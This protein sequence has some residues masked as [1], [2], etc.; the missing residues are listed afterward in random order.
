MFERRLGLEM[1]EQ[2]K[3]IGGALIF[4]AIF[5]V[6]TTIGMIIV[7]FKTLGTFFN[8][9]IISYILNNIDSF[10]F[11]Y[12]S[13]IISVI[14][15]LLQLVLFLSSLF[16]ILLFFK[17]DKLFPSLFIITRIATLLL[18]LANRMMAG[19][20]VSESSSASLLE[21]A[22]SMEF[23]E[24]SFPTVVWCSYILLSRRV[25][26]TFVENMFI[27]SAKST[28]EAQPQNKEEDHIPGLENQI[29]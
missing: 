4:V 24:I 21:Y 6:I 29:Q 13:L 28:E 27:K 1:L 14:E 15:I 11:G 16:L 3:G 9:E 12:F 22:M 8:Y 7:F 23:T 19:V 17:K 26:N 10:E 25:K 18:L 2:K 5:M 20:T